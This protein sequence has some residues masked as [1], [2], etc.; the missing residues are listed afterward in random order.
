MI[1]LATKV[2]HKVNIAFSGG[3]D[4][5][6]A[7][8]FLRNGNRDITLLHFNHGCEFSDRIED[9][10][11][12]R[13]E[14]LGLPI[15]VGQHDGSERPKGRSLEDH[16]RR[17][18]YRFLRS[19]PE[20]TI[21]CHHLDDAVETFV[22]SSLHG[23]GKIIPVESATIIRPFLLTKKQLLIDY[24][25]KHGLEAVH[26]PYNFENGLTRN[27]IRANI[28]QHAYKVNPGLDKVVRKKYLNAQA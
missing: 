4:S 8:H 7:A 1:H 13:A 27:Y 10:C 3:V 19:F 18:R 22:W 23:N 2:P 21:T 24:A 5:L 11:R 28:M 26:D 25:T 16:W 9:E 12:Q 14:S 6:A 17:S 20:K 15:V